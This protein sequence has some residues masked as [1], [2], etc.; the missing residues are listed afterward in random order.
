MQSFREDVFRTFSNCVNYHKDRAATQHLVKMGELASSKAELLWDQSMETAASSVGPDSLDAA[1]NGNVSS[2]IP[3]V[4]IPG[5]EEEGKA[6]SAVSTFSS[7]RGVKA[8]SEFLDWLKQLIQRPTFADFVHDV[9]VQFFPRYSEFVKTPMCLLQIWNNVCG[10]KYKSSA[11]FKLDVELVYS[12][13][14]AFNSVNVKIAIVA[15]AL[16]EEIIMFV[17]QNSA[18]F[19]V[20]LES[21]QDEAVRL[22]FVVLD[23]PLFFFLLL[24]C[25]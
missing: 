19:E 1:S 24:P 10:G 22:A 17:D 21:F 13:C 23:S 8:A 16:N 6:E 12:N 7:E 2:H 5:L 20:A 14:V 3:P 18:F 4:S 15:C 11:D 9:D 25:V